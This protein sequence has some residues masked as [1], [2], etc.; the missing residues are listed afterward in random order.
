MV[1]RN[2]Q[3]V[4]SAG[5]NVASRPQVGGFSETASVE[6]VPW[7]E[8]WPKP[9]A[10]GQ[11]AKSRGR[12]RKS[13]RFTGNQ[14]MQDSPEQAGSATGRQNTPVHGWG[15]NAGRFSGN[16]TTK[17]GQEQAGLEP[18]RQAGRQEVLERLA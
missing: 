4:S 9:A 10:T 15:R 18:G 1:G 2:Q 5:T 16:Q 11:Q 17:A 14:A 12:G 13:G 3:S 8:T 7:R 6:R